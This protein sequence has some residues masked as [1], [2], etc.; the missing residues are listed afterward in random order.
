[1]KYVQCRPKTHLGYIDVASMK[2]EGV[3][4]LNYYIDFF[5]GGGTF[6]HDKPSE[7]FPNTKESEN[8]L[9]PSIPFESGE[10]SHFEPYFS[11]F[12]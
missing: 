3:I 12:G 1:M 6:H 8:P 9:F 11:I 7:L 4:L 2:K 10:D 5:L